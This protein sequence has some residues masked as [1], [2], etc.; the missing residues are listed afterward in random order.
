MILDAMEAMTTKEPTGIAELALKFYEEIKGPMENRILVLKSIGIHQKDLNA[1]AAYLVTAADPIPC[2]TLQDLEDWTGVKSQTPVMDILS[3]LQV[4]SLENQICTERMAVI[5]TAI[6]K[7]V[8]KMD[9][10]A[11]DPPMEVNETTVSVDPSRE[12]EQ[13]ESSLRMVTGVS[14]H[15]KE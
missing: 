5:L 15:S 8:V 9:K 7:K 3:E 12:E 2:P 10:A 14:A 11:S 1:A 13:Q 6:L 4:A